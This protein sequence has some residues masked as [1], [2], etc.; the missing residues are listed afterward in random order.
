M[1]QDNNTLFEI[2][3]GI[4]WIAEAEPGPTRPVSK[5]R[6]R[7]LWTRFRRGVRRVA[8][9]GFLS[10]VLAV[11]AITGEAV[12]RARL[13]PVET[14][15]P[16]RFYARPILL[17]QGDRL[18]LAMVEASLR[19]LGYE[20]TRNRNVAEGQYRMESRKITIGRRAFRV[21]DKVD[22]GGLT[23]ARLSGG[24][25]SSLRD[26]RGRPIGSALLERELRT[27][28]DPTGRL[29][30][31]ATQRPEN[32]RFYRNLGFSVASERVLGSRSCAFRNWIMVR[33]PGG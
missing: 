24:R 19:R 16:T 25:I 15:T 29:A 26:G 17:R 10:A 32:V 13:V 9:L 23:V 20:S 4:P 11:A 5:Q 14:R 12:V 30:A 1:S 8:Q 21:F 6:P 31:L 7:V 2:A 27:R 28:I 33:K 18:N 3:V 22:L